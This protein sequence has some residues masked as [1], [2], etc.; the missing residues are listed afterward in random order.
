MSASPE[1]ATTR[2]IYVFVPNLIGYARIVMALAAFV[3]AFDYPAAFLV[4]Y[5]MSFVLDAADGW[6]ARKLGQSS[7]FGAILDMFTD[8]AATSAV[9]VVI[10]HVVTPVARWQVLAGAL[11]VFLDVA[12]HFVR[13]YASLFGG[14][15]S[16]KDTSGSIFTLLTLYYSNRNVMGAFCVGQEFAYI[17]YYANFFYG[18]E[19]NA[20]LY[21]LYISV[22]LCLLKQ[23]VNVQQLLDAMY[24][25]AVQD[26]ELRNSN[27]KKL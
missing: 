5:S 22:P 6:A 9:I 25:I 27:K 13:M 18:S 1:K 26:A 3:V 16:H 23:V 11:L 2:D 8:R 20:I 10:S 17:L 24:H 21:A 12:S 19:S 7:N 14:K 4:L 15:T